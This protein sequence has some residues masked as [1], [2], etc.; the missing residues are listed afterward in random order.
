MLIDISEKIKY[1]NIFFSESDA[2]KNIY[3]NLM[4]VISVLNPFRNSTIKVLLYNC[5][6]YFF[7]YNNRRL[8]RIGDTDIQIYTNIYKFEK[9]HSKDDI[10]II[11]KVTDESSSIVFND[12]SISKSYKI[13]CPIINLNFN[14][15]EDRQLMHSLNQYI[16]V[17]QYDNIAVQLYMI[18]TGLKHKSIYSDN[19]CCAEILHK[20]FPTVNFQDLILLSQAE[21]NDVIIKLITDTNELS[22]KLYEQDYQTL[23]NGDVN[24]PFQI[25]EIKIPF[26]D[27]SYRLEC[28]DNDLL[29]INNI[30]ELV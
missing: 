24:F 3:N 17:F 11:H 7:S 2:I 12:N 10:A 5:D 19:N 15:L 30:M 20:H 23:L 29:L 9:E 13:R 4:R 21:E 18:L 1:N 14:W 25:L 6:Q 16:S 28:L 8:N 22:I 26:D 27:L